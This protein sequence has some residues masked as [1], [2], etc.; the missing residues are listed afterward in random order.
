MANAVRTD[1][2]DQKE[3]FV[4]IFNGTKAIR[5]RSLSTTKSH[6]W[7]TQ[8]SCSASSKSDTWISGWNYIELDE[9]DTAQLTEFFFI[10]SCFASCSK[11]YNE[12]ER[13]GPF[14]T[15]MCTVFT[16]LVFVPQ[17]WMFEQS[18]WH[19]HFFFWQRK[20]NRC[21]TI[22]QESYNRMKQILYII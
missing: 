17:C 10:R 12:N 14:P 22:F 16:F 2:Y 4:G 6:H 7:I 3:E 19:D 20:S 9:W 5:C 21:F 11:Q 18:K 15:S 13:Q 8:I 1:F